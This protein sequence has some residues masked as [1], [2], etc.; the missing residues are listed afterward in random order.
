MISISISA[1]G[2]IKQ[3]I[4]EE[5]VIQIS[6]DRQLNDLKLDVGI[7]SNQVCG[8]MV[9]GSIKRGTD[10]L[11]DGDDLKFIMLVGAG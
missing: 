1:T 6:E 10:T 8:F 5:K 9:N 7:P 11:C 4:S 3:F 2:K